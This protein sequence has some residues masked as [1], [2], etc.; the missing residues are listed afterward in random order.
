MY[1]ALYFEASEHTTR[2][3]VWAL[4][5]LVSTAVSTIDRI[6][7][8]ARFSVAGTY[9]QDESGDSP[10]VQQLFYGGTTHS[11]LLGRML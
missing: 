9:T 2:C 4:V 11:A 7:H 10:G 1:K 6:D 5:Q 3:L 8:L